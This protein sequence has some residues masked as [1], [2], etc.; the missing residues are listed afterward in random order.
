MPARRG[1]ANSW[2]P[3]AARIQRHAGGECRG[4][5]IPPMPGMAWLVSVT[6]VPEAEL[7]EPCRRRAAIE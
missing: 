1:T 4:S 2:R 7:A 6:S 3:P 5:V